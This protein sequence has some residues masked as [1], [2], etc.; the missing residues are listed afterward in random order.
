MRSFFFGSFNL[1]PT[2]TTLIKDP[3]IIKFVIVISLASKEINFGSDRANSWSS[4][5]TGCSLLIYKSALMP[6]L[7]RI[8]NKVISIDV[9]GS[10]TFNE[11]S[12]NDHLGAI[13][14][15]GAWV[16]VSGRWNLTSRFNNL[17][18]MTAHIKSVHILILFVLCWPTIQ[19]QIVTVRHKSVVRDLPWRSSSLIDLLPLVIV[20]WNSF[21]IIAQ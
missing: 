14:W 11:P 2:L 20:W 6:A 5:F 19:I 12:K 4:S 1:T 17:P 16:I 9:V 13:R 8:S 7:P 18:L 15:S 21:R 3:Q 10:G